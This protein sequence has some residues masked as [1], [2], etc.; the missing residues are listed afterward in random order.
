MLLA[1]YD[2]LGSSRIFFYRKR[3]EKNLKVANQHFLRYTQMYLPHY[4][5]SCIK[6]ITGDTKPTAGVVRG[7]GGGPAHSREKCPVQ[8]QRPLLLFSSVSQ[9][10]SVLL[11]YS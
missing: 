10:V 4:K 8:C 2:P 11:K 3:N 5:M 7:V 6:M 9:M 1:V